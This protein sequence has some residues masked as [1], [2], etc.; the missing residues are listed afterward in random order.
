VPGKLRGHLRRLL[1]ANAVVVAL[2][3]PSGAQAAPNI[4]LVLTDDQRW[5]TLGVMPTVQRE[6]VRRGVT[7]ANA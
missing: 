4:V 7:F 2:A 6:L 5:D 3:V 1:L